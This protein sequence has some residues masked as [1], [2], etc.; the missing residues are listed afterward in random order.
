MAPTAANG[1]TAHMATTTLRVEGMTCGACTSA[2]ESGFTGVAG[3]GNVSISLV[4]ERAVIQHD[5]NVITTEQIREIIDDR[6]F[7]AEVLSTDIP[8]TPSADDHFLS[9]SE[10]E[11]EDVNTRI[12]TTTLSVGGMTCGA[13][14]SAVEGAF[15]DVAGIKSF[16]I[17]LLSERAVIEHDTTIIPADKLA[18]TI[19]DV[20]FDAEVLDTVAAAPAS[21]KH[22]GQKKQKTLTTT[23]SVEGMT[24]GACTSAIEGGFKDVEG[25]YQFNISLLANRAV[26]VHDPSKLTAEQIV[27]I[28]DDRGFDAAVISSVDGSVAQSSGNNGLVHFKVYGLPNASAA[29]ELEALLRKRSGITT[30]TVNFST[31]R[32]TIQR[33]PQIVGLRALVEVIEEAGYNALVADSE[34]NN[35][36]LES[37]AKTKEI[38]EWRRAVV[39]SAWFAVPVFLTSMFIPMFLPFLDYG[40][41]RII[42]GL[43]LGDIVCLAL[44]IPVQF[45]IGKR[46]YVSAYKS[47]SHGSPTMDV[48]VVLGTSA[49]FFFSIASMLV[50]LFVPPHSKPTTLF[51][52]STM[53]ITFISLGRYLENSAKGQ[54]SKALSNLM[55]LAPSMATIYADPIAA[56]KAAEGWDFDEKSGRASVDGNAAEEKVIAT[57]LIEVGDVVILR[58]GDK[59]PADGTVTRG[60]S[61][62]DESMVTGEAMP[63]L[64]KKGALLMAGTVNGHGRVEF[65]VTRAGR[66]TQL[67]QIVRLVQEAQ[68]SRAPIQRLADT[69]A[70]YFVPIIIT[71]GLAT[72]VTWMILSHVLPYPPKMFL[73]H[74]SGGKIMVCV[75]LCIAVIVF[76]CPCALGLATP[77]AVMV[78]TGVGAE[79]G[80]LVKGGAAL[81]TATKISHVVFDKTGTLTVGKMSVS[82][83]DIQGEWASK[84]NLWWT[85]IGLAEMGSEHPI[86]KAIVLAAKDNLR[87]GPDGILD[88]SVGDFEAVVGKGISANVEAALSRERTRYRV[89]IGNA[90]YLLSEGVNVPSVIDEP[91][92]SSISL[93]PQARSAGITTI[94]TAIGTTYTGTLSL[95]DTIKPSARAAVLA[96]TRLGITSSIVTG[97]TSASALVVAAAVGIDAAD[98]HASATPSDKKSMVA[99]LQ[100]RGYVIG[101]VG[102]G[103]NDSPALASADIGIALSTGTD[104]AMEAASIVLMSNADLLAIP[105]SLVLSRAIFR[106]IKINLAW[107]C[108]YN[109]I[110]LPF[111]MG[112]FLPWGLS[113][114]PMAAGAAMACSSVSVVASSLHLKFWTRPKWMKVSVLDPSAEVPQSEVEAE[115]QRAGRKGVWG[116][117]REWVVEAWEARRRNKEEGA[118]YVPLRDLGE[119]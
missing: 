23:L 112:F 73:D 74:A 108:M 5:P 97:D 107:A 88:G 117:A 22:K 76:A 59:I 114:H 39:F 51:D 64:K 106:R 96:L 21:K 37:L 3:V 26:L 45:G 111:A 11:D 1:A 68:T 42:P 2:I 105:A 80:I 109:L 116:T 50:S 36:Q 118:K 29:E 14:T 77:T 83:A 20:G 35:A 103:I 119:H 86:A 31:S 101:M 40:S 28:I 24:C 49:A 7:D 56:A 92:M 32:A 82:K 75:K 72:F 34:D 79:Q 69:V 19:E 104:V 90:T 16:S 48:L 78:G 30:A 4:M 95:S 62:V 102:D 89:L 99:D 84:K 27:E 57:E 9:D 55:S 98:V 91:S 54:T 60:E 15:K 25:V 58:P 52:T 17:S 44:T 63:I 70:G 12:S 43:F 8:M 67:S 87:L 6:G 85:L 38:Q 93:N 66:D 61:Y 47:L 46:F 71:L 18:E 100:S 65:V 13:C 10:D 81:E 110:G 115:L 53:L 113:L 94:H 33:E 41:I